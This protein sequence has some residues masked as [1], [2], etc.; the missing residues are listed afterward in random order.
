MQPKQITEIKKFLEIAKGNKNAKDAKGKPIKKSTYT[1]NV[2]VMIK[3]NKKTIKFKIRQ[4]KYLYTFRPEKP[5][6]A[7]KL[8]DALDSNSFEKVEIKKRIVRKAK[9]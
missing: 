2:A 3:K 4:G 9:K 6:H 7:K 8:T 1:S 5:E